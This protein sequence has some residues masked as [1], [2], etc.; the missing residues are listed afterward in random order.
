MKKILLW[1]MPSLFM[2]LSAEAQDTIWFDYNW[3]KCQKPASFYYRIET[4]NKDTLFFKDYYSLNHQIQNTGQRVKGRNDGVFLR[5]YAENGQI[6]QETN[7]SMGELEGME[8]F[9]HQDGTPYSKTEY[10]AGKQVGETLVFDAATQTWKPLEEGQPRGI[11]SE[12][13]PASAQVMEKEPAPLNLQEVMGRMS[14]PPT[15]K[16]K[17]IEGKVVIRVYVDINGKVIKHVILKPLHPEAD[18][19]IV[20]LVYLL[21]FT[22]AIQEGKPIKCWVTMPFDYK[23]M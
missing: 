8:S 17:K 2:V 11:E 16:K 1:L 14:Y 22:P 12:F 6:S 23:L 18:A 5:Y 4:K 10:H 9:W 15:M 20:E 21:R 19:Q 3:D 13:N 7:Y